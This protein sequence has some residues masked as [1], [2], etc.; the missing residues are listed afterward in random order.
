MKKETKQILDYLHVIFEVIV[1]FTY[2]VSFVPAAYYFLFFITIPL[3]IAVLIFSLQKKDKAT[4]YIV[5]NLILSILVFI[6]VLGYL[7]L[8]G[9]IVMSILSILIVMP[10]L[11]VIK[12]NKNNDTKEDKNEQL[13]ID[14]KPE[15]VIEKESQN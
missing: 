3:L 11:K 6:P 13:I 2:I 4:N 12:T 8:I 10:E 14:S 7:A 5:I 1:I 9:G 15:D